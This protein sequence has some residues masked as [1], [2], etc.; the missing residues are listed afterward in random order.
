MSAVIFA[1]VI[2][3]IVGPGFLGM[4]AVLLIAMRTEGSYL[5]PTNAPHTRTERTAR[6]LV[7][8]YVRRELE[9]MQVRSDV[10]R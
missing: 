9:K 4:I 3:A 1:L 7:G 10:R 8:L 6:R 5:S 2:T